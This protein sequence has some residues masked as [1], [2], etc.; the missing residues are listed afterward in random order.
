[1]IPPRFAVT[2]DQIAAVVAEFYTCVRQHPGL[3]PVF[4]AHVQDWPAHEAKI[5]RFWKNAILF[6]RGYDGNPLAVHRAAGD[7]RI[8]MFDVWLGLFDSVL[9]RELPSETAAAWSALVHRIG[10]G[11]VFG[12]GQAEG[13]PPSLR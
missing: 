2:E 10:R 12:L 8:P 3:G 4:A 1:M 11:L 7:V 5:T 6:D 9:R 13:A